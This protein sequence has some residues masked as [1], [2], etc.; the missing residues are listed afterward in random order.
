LTPNCEQRD[1][2]SSPK[3]QVDSNWGDPN[4][5]GLAEVRFIYDRHVGTLI[6]VY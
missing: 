5:V 4:Y 6:Y 3:V 1:F 2:W